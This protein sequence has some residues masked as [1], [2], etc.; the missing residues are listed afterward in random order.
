M[1]VF[2]D[3]P[4]KSMQRTIHNSGVIMKL[5]EHAHDCEECKLFRT[6]ELDVC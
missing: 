6:V 1:Y 2:G 4:L 5:K 3:S